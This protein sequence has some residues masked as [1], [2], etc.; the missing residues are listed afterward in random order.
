[1]RKK[2]RDQRLKKELTQKELSEILGIARTT[3][4]NIELGNKDPSLE[5]S[6]KIKIALSYKSDD[7]FF[8]TNEPKRNN[9]N[10]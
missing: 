2:L 8:I 3:Y 5:L 1:M 4:T 7:I 10:Q 9:L 6:Y